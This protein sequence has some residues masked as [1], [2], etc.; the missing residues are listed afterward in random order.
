[1]SLRRIVEV[2]FPRGKPRTSFPREANGTAGKPF[3]IQELKTAASRMFPGKSPGLDGIPNEVIR[4]VVVKKP[5][6]LLGVY[7]KCL[8]D[9]TFPARWK[10]QKLVLIPKGKAGAATDPSAYR[11]LGMIDSAGKLF[12]RLILNRMEKVIEKAEN[13]GISPN[14]F[15]F[16]SKGMFTHH[17]LQKVGE[18]VSEALYE[19]PKRGGYCAIIALDVKNAFNS[20]SWERIYKSLEEDKKMPQY[21]LKILNSYLTGRKLVIVTRNDK[22]EIDLTAGVPQGSIKGSFMWN[23]MYAG[24]LRL[25]IPD[26]DNLVGFADDLALVVVAEE[27]WQTELIANEALE[28][29]ANWL[30]SRHLQ[31]AVHKCEA[32]LVTRRRKY[33]PPQLKFNGELIPLKSEIKCLGVWLDKKWAFKRHIEEAATNASIAYTSLSRLVPNI[34][35]PWPKHRILLSTVVESIQLYAAP[36]WAARALSTDVDKHMGAVQRKMNLRIISGWRSISRDAANVLTG[37][38]PVKLLALERSK[39]W[40]EQEEQRR[41]QGDLSEVEKTRI[42]E[43]ARDALFSRWQEEWDASGDGRWTH[44]HILRVKE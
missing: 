7:N 21:I 35:G 6:L 39:V 31:L 32:F 16:R 20:A 14:Q 13:E 10:R 29:I 4:L 24:L 1:M 11:P 25:K 34:G 41:L 22:I 15:R 12:E 27:A 19:L 43:E 42:R 38:S 40:H 8:A 33:D 5:Q 26:G 17:A 28:L 30:N 9:G 44:A 36:T 3:S 23:C 37:M 18:R 2:L